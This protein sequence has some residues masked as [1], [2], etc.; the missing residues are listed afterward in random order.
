MSYLHILRAKRQGPVCMKFTLKVGC[1]DIL[2]NCKNIKANN[3]TKAH[4]SMRM[5]DLSDGRNN[6]IVFKL[7]IP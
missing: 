1:W 2:T 5:V 6:I 3:T 4:K 7:R